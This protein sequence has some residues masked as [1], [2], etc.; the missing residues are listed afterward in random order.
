MS[1]L[2]GLPRLDVTFTNHG[3][4][5]HSLDFHGAR[6]APDRGYRDV[7]PG[8]TLRVSFVVQR[9]GVTTMFGEAE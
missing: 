7:A 4:M 2:P 9:P 8:H 5:P 3:S 1:R 6:V